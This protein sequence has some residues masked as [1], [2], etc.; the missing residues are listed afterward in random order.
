V[1]GPGSAGRWPAGTCSRV[2]FMRL[3]ATGRHYLRFLARKEKPRCVS[4]G[5]F[6]C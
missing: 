3:P 1:L 2:M 4:S 6:G 5:V